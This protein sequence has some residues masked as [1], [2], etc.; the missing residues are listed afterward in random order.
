MMATL[1]ILEKWAA[2]YC[3]LS[4]DDDNEG[5]SNS[6]ANQKKILQKYAMENGYTNFKF[7][8]DDGYSGTNF[9]RPGFQE[10]IADIEAGNVS[11]V[12]IKD[13]SRFGRDYLQ[14]GM[15]TEIMFPEQNI[16]F[17]AINDGVDSE[18]GDNEFTPFRNII[19]EWY[20][21]DTSKKIR[22]VNQAKGKAGEHLSTHA[23][24]GYIKDPDNPK[25]W[26]VDEDAA[27]IVRRIFNLCVNGIGPTQIAT[28]LNAESVPTPTAYRTKNGLSGA[29]G[30]LTQAAERWRSATVV[31]I[32][33]HKEYLGHTVNFK[34]YRKSY[35]QKKK[36]DNPEE[37]QLVFEN[38]HE[39]IIEPEVFE[40]VQKIRQQR[41]RVTRF[42]DAGLFSGL[43]FCADC[44]KKMY[45]CRSHNYTQEYYT[46]STY[47]TDVHRC[48]AHYIG[49]QALT[50]V[51]QSELRR[52]IGFAS[53]YEDQFVQ[54]VMHNSMRDQK[55]IL[56]VK[57]KELVQFQKRTKELDILFQKIYEDNVSGKLNDERFSKLSATYE[58]EQRDLRVKT[59]EYEE[60]IST[61]ENQG[62]NVNS[63][64]RIVRKYTEITELTAAMLNE[65]VEKIIVHASDKSNGKR[66]QKIDIYFN[67]VGVVD[68]PCTM[69]ETLQRKMA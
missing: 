58:T 29:S 4:R 1:N 13:M 2:L 19:N 26:V 35:K 69:E 55:R 66:T 10:M 33:E 43:L 53:A 16:H 32:L 21:K 60:A 20:A 50:K 3:R 36:C 44:G 30:G 57:Q 28:R 25:K 46:C 49:I 22:A 56:A 64:L 37:K 17:I 42:G 63:F 34:T 9:N 27:E 14:V 41:R 48:T 52:I 45:Y 6:I 23:P 62:V 5:D 8:I 7:F 11:T 51:V 54:M 18:K 38:T 15:Y 59:S 31:H 24:F 67:F 68:D 39:A 47:R 61:Q 12:I 40:L 65:F